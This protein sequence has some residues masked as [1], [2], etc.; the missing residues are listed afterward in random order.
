[1][2]DGRLL[3]VR[4]VAERA[5]IAEQTVRLLIARGLLPV[6]RPGGLRAVRVTEEDFSRVVLDRRTGRAARRPRGGR[7]AP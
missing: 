1:M 4:N 5:Q 7:R 2:N 6:V 3:T